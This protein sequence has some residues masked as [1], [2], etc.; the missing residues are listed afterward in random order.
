MLNE[1]RLQGGWIRHSVSAD[2]DMQQRL[3][4]ANDIVGEIL[5]QKKKKKILL[6]NFLLCLFICIRIHVDMGMQA[7]TE[8][9]FFNFESSSQF[10]QHVFHVD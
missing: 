9:H 7:G 8:T 3:A 5:Y 2:E 1:R 10:F 4:H 6:V